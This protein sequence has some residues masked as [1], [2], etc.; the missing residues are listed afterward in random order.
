MIAIV[1]A[2]IVSRSSWSAFSGVYTSG[3]T[4]PPKNAKPYASVIAAL[5]SPERRPPR[6]L[7]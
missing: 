2:A 5:T 7:E 1:G 3:R 4:G 6:K